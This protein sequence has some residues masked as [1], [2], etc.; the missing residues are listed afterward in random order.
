MNATATTTSA[1]ARG[2]AATRRRRVVTGSLAAVTVVLAL[3]GLRYG[4]DPMGLD[5]VLAAIL[6]GPD[7]GYPWMVVTQ[8]RAPRVFGA[9]AFG[10]ALGTA[11]ALFQTITRN[12]L[13]SPDII[14]FTTGAYTG[15]LISLTVVG[16][17]FLSTAA[18]A[19]LGGLATGVI[20][21]LLAYRGGLNGFRLIIVGIGVTAMLSALNTW[22]L[23]RAQTE[24]AMA[25]SIWAAGS[26]NLVSWDDARPV[27]IALAVLA[28]VVWL[29]VPSLRQL[30]LGDDAARAHGVAVEP[31]RLTVLG[32]GVALTA[33]VT[34][35]AGPIAFIA[36]VAPQVAHRLTRGGGLPMLASAL[37][38]GAL[39]LLADLAAQF[40]VPT[41]VPVGTVTV[42]I[43][44]AYLIALL[45]AEARRRR[46]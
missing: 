10:A 32:I 42:V 14:G 9:I 43:G 22:L 28:P 34:A 23:L 37:T 35:A 31:V 6:G 2:A 5:E 19:L 4:D 21:Y 8:W 30:E 27:L 38:G 40:V 13:G 1:S 41:P 16:T 18:G 15:A 20:V 45:V 33:A 26:I 46:S 25:A 7:E 39:L 44:G 12:P 36:L 24:V 11:G 29:A 17:A 3:V